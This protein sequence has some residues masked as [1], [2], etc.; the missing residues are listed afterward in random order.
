[1]HL[2]KSEGINVY[3]VPKSEIDGGLFDNSLR[4]AEN[5]KPPECIESVPFVRYCAKGSLWRHR[6]LGLEAVSAR[7]GIRSY[8]CDY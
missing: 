4:G 1:M 7:C 5:F 8:Y 3:R 2:F 6:V